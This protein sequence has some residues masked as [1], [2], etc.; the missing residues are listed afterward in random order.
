MRELFAISDDKLKSLSDISEHPS[1]PVIRS[2]LTK[3][4]LLG[5]EHKA[6]PTA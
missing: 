4:Q 6:L 3:T 5:V 2:G 1:Q